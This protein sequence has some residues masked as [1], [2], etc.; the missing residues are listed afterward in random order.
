MNFNVSLNL[1]SVLLFFFF[2]L[3]KVFHCQAYL[4]RN[5]FHRLLFT[6]QL[7]KGR[8]ELIKPVYL[9]SKLG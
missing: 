5:T 3:L 4:L 6:L 2:F 9:R 7:E 1:G 8:E